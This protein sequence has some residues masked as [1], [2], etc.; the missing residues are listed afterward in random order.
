VKIANGVNCNDLNNE[1]F[2]KNDIKNVPDGFIY[3]IKVLDSPFVEHLIQKFFANFGRIG[4]I[5]H[6]PNLHDIII[7]KYC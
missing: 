1:T 6:E 5:D 4:I 3:P 2:Q 7:Q